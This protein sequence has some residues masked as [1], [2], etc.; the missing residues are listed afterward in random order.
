MKRKA[1]FTSFIVGIFMISCTPSKPDFRGIYWREDKA[2]ILDNEKYPAEV[3]INEKDYIIFETKLKNY[4]VWIDYSLDEKYGCYMGSYKFVQ[5]SPLKYYTKD[6]A[7][8][9]YHEFFEELTSKYGKPDE[10]EIA[11][12][13]NKHVTWKR[14]RTSILLILGGEQLVISSGCPLEIR[15][16]DSNYWDWRIKQTRVK[17]E[18]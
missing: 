8:K 10:E 5:H 4:P 6:E 12:T 2:K 17:N 7:R 13:D 9:M 1:L 11:D 16:Y 3:Y 14:R 15:Y 18:L